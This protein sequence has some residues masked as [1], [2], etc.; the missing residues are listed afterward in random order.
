M[1]DDEYNSPVKMAAPCDECLLGIHRTC[2]HT[3]CSA[4]LVAVNICSYGVVDEIMINI[5]YPSGRREFRSHNH[6]DEL[7]SNR[8]L[9][10]TLQI[11]D[12]QGTDQ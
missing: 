2:S 7:Q 9:G 10:V 6:S 1:M 11:A 12:A 5:R 4:A 3:V 8:V